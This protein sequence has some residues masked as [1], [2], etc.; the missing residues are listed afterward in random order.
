MIRFRTYLQEQ[1]MRGLSRIEQSKFDRALGVGYEIKKAT[2]KTTTITVRAPAADRAKM[3]RDVEAKLKRAK[4]EFMGDDVGG[5]SIG[6][7]KVNFPRHNVTIQYKPASGSGGMSETTLNATI[8]ELFP[9]LAFMA[10]KRFTNST[11][12]YNFVKT[13]RDN[14]VYLSTRDREQ[15]KKF[16]TQAAGSSK[17]DD[18]MDAAIGILK[19]LHDENAKS[20]IAN[21]YWGYR[22]KPRGVPES[23]KGDLFVKYKSGDMKGVS[24]KA[25]TAKTKEPLLNT[26]VNKLFDQFND[27]RGKNALKK[28]IYEKIHSKMNLPQDWQSR[29]K[30]AD[31]IEKIQSILQKTPDYYE[32]KYDE[33]LELCR[34]AV[35]DRIKQDKNAT[36]KYI[37][38][39]VIGKADN[40]PLEVVK[41][42]G[43]GRYQYV[44]DDEDLAIFLPT[45]TSV[46]AEASASSKQNWS[47]ILK[48]KEDSITMNMSIRSNQSPPNNKIA[49]GFNLAIKFNGMAK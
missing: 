27:E 26:F 36:L 19:Y 22:E 33:M 9:A 10:G 43:G 8:T 7:T 12:F 48:N 28:D 40:V 18:K 2:T 23:H 47:I 37:E 1:T 32:E 30:K 25:G 46:D 31:S 11:Q 45:V 35:I 38:E 17:F 42:V 13:A 24:L 49:Q 29:G 16:I 6:Q 39:V 3:R 15:G 44:T 5:G 4:I 20:P 41:A 21:V 14:G 34:Q